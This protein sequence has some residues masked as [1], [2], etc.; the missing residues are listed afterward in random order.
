LSL[1][2][3]SLTSETEYTLF[4][5]DINGAGSYDYL[6]HAKLYSCKCQNSL[7]NEEYEFIPVRRNSDGAVGLLDILHDT[8]YGSATGVGFIAGPEAKENI[9]YNR[10]KQYGSPNLAYNDINYYSYSHSAF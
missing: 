3:T 7:F 4:G 9:L 2:N 10:W 8:F 5:L 6:C 1:T